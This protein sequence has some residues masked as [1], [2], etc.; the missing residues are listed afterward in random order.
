[1]RSATERVREQLRRVLHGLSD[2]WLRISV[3][4][5]LDGAIP[6]PA[7]L[8]VFTR[9]VPLPR[10]GGRSVRLQSVLHQRYLPTSSTAACSI[11]STCAAARSWP[12]LMMC[13]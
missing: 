11:C 8:Q 1:M 6:Q 13:C 12:V 9:S 5:E 3:S 10:H 4:A 7:Q 2:A